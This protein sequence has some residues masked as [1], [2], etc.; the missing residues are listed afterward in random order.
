MA[1]ITRAAANSPSSDDHDDPEH[2]SSATR[3]KSI[4]L[5]QDP[6]LGTIDPA[7]LLFSDRPHTAPVNWSSF[8]HIFVLCVILVV[9]FAL[10]LMLGSFA[11]EAIPTAP[12]QG[13]T[14]FVFA[15]LCEAPSSNNLV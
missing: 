13:T 11:L 14:G 7:L 3:L 9:V 5:L 8:R 2:A 6:S 12:I 4:P 10:L 15:L 1:L